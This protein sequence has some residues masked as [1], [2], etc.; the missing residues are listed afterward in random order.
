MKTAR[1]VGSKLKIFSKF[2]KYETGSI[3][4]ENMEKKW[5]RPF[6]RLTKIL[7]D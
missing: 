3:I 1:P 7:H 4:L 5:L 2:Q 6:T